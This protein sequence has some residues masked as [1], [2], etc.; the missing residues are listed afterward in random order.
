MAIMDV[1]NSVGTVF[2]IRGDGNVGIGTTSPAFTLDISGTSNAAMR[3]ISKIA[4]STT[5]RL[6]TFNDVGQE[7]NNRNWAF[8]NRYNQYGKLELMRSTNSTD[9]PLTTVMSWDNSGNVIVSEGNLTLLSGL[10][11]QTGAG[12]NSFAGNVGIGTADPGTTKLQVYGNNTDTTPTEIVRL[13]NGANATGAGPKLAF[14]TTQT[15]VGWITGIQQT[16]QGGDITISTWN[17]PTEIEGIRITQAGDVCGADADLSNCA[18]DVR[19]KENIES[20]PIGLNEILQLNPVE[21]NWNTVAGELGF[22][23]EK[24]ALGFIAQEVETIIPEWVSTNS[25]GYKK[26]DGEGNLRYALVKAI[27]ELNTKVDEKD[28]EINELKQRISALEN[29]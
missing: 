14:G 24:R 29:K 10:L 16:A 20:Y 5:L 12:N 2:S 17:S 7:A 28:A 1:V 27:Q 26:V 6:D 15:T 25:E 22:D 9:N 21:F 23:T 19:L 8:R 18:S 3:L 13:T 11:T 4:G